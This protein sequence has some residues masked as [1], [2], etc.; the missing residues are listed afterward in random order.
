MP[1]QPQHGQET[2]RHDIAARGRDYGVCLRA[3]RR[4]FGPKGVVLKCGDLI[5]DKSL[6]A[7]V[8]V[9]V[10]GMKDDA[11][12]VPVSVLQILRA[13]GTRW[14]TQLNVDREVTNSAGYVGFNF[15]DDTH[16]FP[17]YRV[18]FTSN[19]AQWGDRTPLQFTLV[20]A[21]MDRHGRADPDDF[22][23][24]IGWNPAVG[25]FQEI[26]PNG[27]DFVPEVKNPKHINGR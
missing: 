5:G 26:E 16:P 9:R 24:A 4:E 14:D 18:N 2:I 3:A 13:N 17:F 6:E 15:I 23:L 8:A 21:S 25:R 1:I 10:P 20:L 19:G 7:V 27:D 12:G 11:D 22:G